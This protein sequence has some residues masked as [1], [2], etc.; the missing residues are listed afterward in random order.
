MKVKVETI[1]LRL[2]RLGM[3]KTYQN[4]LNRT[5]EYSYASGFLPLALL[6]YI[7]ED[8]TSQLH[9]AMVLTGG[10]SHFFSYYSNMF[11][12]LYDDIFLRWQ[13]RSLSNSSTLPFYI[14][15]LVY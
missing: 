5:K 11:E 6:V 1:P 12:Y 15:F 2:E 7:K 9:A 8:K 3:G 14:C 10:F 4:N 13:Q